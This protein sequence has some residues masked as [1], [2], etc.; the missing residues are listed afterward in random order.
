MIINISKGL[1]DCFRE[2]WDKKYSQIDKRTYS[3]MIGFN[4]THRYFNPSYA[5]RKHFVT[6]AV[7]FFTCTVYMSHRN[8]KDFRFSNDNHMN[9]ENFTKETMVDIDYKE[10]LLQEILRNLE[11][12]L[13]QPIE[14][15]WVDQ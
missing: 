6:Y 15:Q 3:L 1:Y 9:V 10:P 5:N 13:G 4:E 14:I 8:W 11:R 12:V 7:E 2:N